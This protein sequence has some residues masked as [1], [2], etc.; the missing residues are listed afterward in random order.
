MLSAALAGLDLG[1][2]DRRAAEAIRTLDPETI[3]AVASLLRRAWQAG[4]DVGRAEQVD[5]HP[6]VQ[7]LDNALAD[8]THE[9]DELRRRLE[10]RD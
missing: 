10:E 9:A 4:V 3:A 6:R 2:V 5:E 7:A 1:A 8:L